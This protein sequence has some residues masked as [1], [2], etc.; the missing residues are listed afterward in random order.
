MEKNL[1]FLLFIPIF[2]PVM[3]IIMNYTKQVK[4]QFPHREGN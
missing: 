4:K 3:K 1:D 2:G